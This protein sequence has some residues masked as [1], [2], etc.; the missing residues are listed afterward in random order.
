MVLSI[1]SA[2]L[3]S[4][5]S[6]SRIQWR[7][8]VT[9]CRANCSTY[10]RPSFWYASFW[11]SSRTHFVTTLGVLHRS[12]KE[13]CRQPRSLLKVAAVFGF[14]AIFFSIPSTVSAFRWTDICDDW[15]NLCGSDDYS[16]RPVLSMLFKELSIRIISKNITVLILLLLNQSKLCLY[17]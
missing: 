5:L 9:N 17:C 14:F 13:R 10:P 11:N 12:T 16:D 2:P 1:R 6:S 8:F 3:S 7:T 4:C 15:C